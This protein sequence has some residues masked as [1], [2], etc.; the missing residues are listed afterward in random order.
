[1]AVNL[2]KWDLFPLSTEDKGLVTVSF[3]NLFIFAWCHSIIT[4]GVTV[5]YPQVTPRRLTC[6]FV[7]ITILA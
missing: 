2:R 3:I 6:G 7:Q 4:I 5:N 1:M